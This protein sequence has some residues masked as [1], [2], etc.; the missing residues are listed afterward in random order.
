VANFQI[1]TEL[2]AI[3]YGVPIDAVTSSTL[4]QRFAPDAF[5]YVGFENDRPFCTAAVI[6]QRKLLYLALVATREDARGKGYG[7]SIVRH[8]LHKAYEATNL[9]KVA[10]HATDMGKPVY[11]RIGFQPIATFRWFMRQP[12]R[13]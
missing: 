12:N 2:N 7:E 11:R 9:S 5:I 4:S 1:L 6:V 8:A 10:L 13:G 3:A